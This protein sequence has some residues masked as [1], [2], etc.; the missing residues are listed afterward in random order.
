VQGGSGFA[1]IRALSPPCQS[2]LLDWNVERSCPDTNIAPAREP[3][4]TCG[5]YPCN[6]V[7]VA[8]RSR[9]I[10]CA[11]WRRYRAEGSVLFDLGL[12]RMPGPLSP[13]SGRNV[14]PA[15]ANTLRIA[16]SVVARALA[17]CSN[18]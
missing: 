6:V 10:N 5:N 7:R 16:S 12:K 17:R 13:S 2:F 14:T 11:A 15:S 9:G 3:K 1:P 18:V 4:P 8:F